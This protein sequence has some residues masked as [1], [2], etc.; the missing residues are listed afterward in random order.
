MRP[1][2][3]SPTEKPITTSATGTQALD[4]E[5]PQNALTS[6]HANTIKKLGSVPGLVDINL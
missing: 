6:A 4:I 1:E 2:Q 5:Y 3:L